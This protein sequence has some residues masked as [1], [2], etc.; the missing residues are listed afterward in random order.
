MK[1]YKFTNGDL[2]T[3]FGTLFIQYEVGRVIHPIGGLA[4][5]W[6]YAYSSLSLAAAMYPKM[7]YEGTRLFEAEAGETRF[8]YQGIA[9]M[10]IESRPLTLIKEIPI[11]HIPLEARI[12]LAIRA[13]MKSPPREFDG[14]WLR[15]ADDWLN[16]DRSVGRAQAAAGMY[17]A[18]A[19]APEYHA[20]HAAWTMSY[21]VQGSAISA[22]C[23]IAATA[24]YGITGSP[25]YIAGTLEALAEE[26]LAKYL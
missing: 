20:C 8:S 25:E 12:E 14:A 10:S 3:R 7:G 6:L 16:G 17:I 1:V 5:K 22:A 26:V 9:D 24:K 21:N 15:W 23:A 4:D 11:P 19:A 18:M 13:A 2:S